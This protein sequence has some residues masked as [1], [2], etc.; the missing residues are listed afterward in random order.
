MPNKYRKFIL[1]LKLVI[2]KLLFVFILVIITF[3]SKDSL[4]ENL[5]IK[6]RNNNDVQNRIILISI[7][8]ATW[9]VM[10]P[11]IQNTKLPHIARLIK[12]GSWGVL[13]SEEP[14]FSPVLWTTIATGKKRERHGITNMAKK[15]GNSF[16]YRCFTSSDRKTKAFWNI[17]TDYGVSVGMINWWATW[18]AEKINGYI[19]SDY[20][21][22]LTSFLKKPPIIEK[23]INADI[24]DVT[25]PESIFKVVQKYQKIKAIP[26]EFSYLGHKSISRSQ[27]IFFIRQAETEEIDMTELKKMLLINRIQTFS[28][29]DMRISLV[30]NYLLKRFPTDLF[31]IYF[32]GLDSVQHSCWEF[33]EPD[34][35]EYNFHPSE[36]EI[37]LFGQVIPEY[38]AWYDKL[39][40]QL[41]D[42][43]DKENTTIMI[44]SDHGFGPFCDPFTYYF[45]LNLLFERLGWLKSKNNKIY[46][47]EASVYSP[48]TFREVYRPI[49]LNLQGREP[50]GVVKLEDYEELRMVTK[51]KLLTLKTQNGKKLF[52]DVRI[53]DNPSKE[54][55]DL[56]VKINPLISLEDELLINSKKSPLKK[57]MIPAPWSGDH[58]HEGI[59][60]M[61]GRYIKTGQIIK[62][63]TIY[64]VTPTILALLGVPIGKD[65][66]GRVLKDI[67]KEECLIKKPLVYIDSHDSD[68]NSK[69]KDQKI[70]PFDEEMKDRLRSI[71]YLQ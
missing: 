1:S 14:M 36:E 32:Q 61:S 34:A 64:D 17:L 40:G 68:L 54:N 15:E 37:D 30:G 25:Y 69:R 9:E 35:I 22:L 62:G 56:E 65:M 38:Y 23:R 11:L 48:P 71:G 60:I 4:P 59:I 66:D 67:I 42:K 3:I 53:A 31:A 8:G 19:V 28:S 43:V 57:F 29:E 50:Y 41:L 21:Q 39:L 2:K 16:N 52:E 24:M 44:I 63:A 13:L 12:E 58:H 55:I 26:E 5:S 47:S 10:W 45:S 7:D 49:C 6:K 33:Y 20:L 51:N 70:S 18:P 46:W 27:A